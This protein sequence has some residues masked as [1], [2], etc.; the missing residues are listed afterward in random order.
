M[1]VFLCNRLRCSDD[2]V[3]CFAQGFE[4]VFI[5]GIEQALFVED[6]VAAGGFEFF[7]DEADALAAQP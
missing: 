1:A 5:W 3:N 4:G 2:R 6:D 7:F